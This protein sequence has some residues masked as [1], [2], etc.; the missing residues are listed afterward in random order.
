MQ[1]GNQSGFAMSFAATLHT[2]NN[3]IYHKENTKKAQR[4]AKGI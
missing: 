4:T 1:I 2:R 3:K